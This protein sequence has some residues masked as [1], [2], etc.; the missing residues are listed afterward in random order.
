MSEFPERGSPPRGLL[1]LGIR[2]ESA[3]H[4]AA[5]SLYRIIDEQVIITVTADGRRDMQSLLARHLMGA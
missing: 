4:A 3:G 5:L 2:E 1:A